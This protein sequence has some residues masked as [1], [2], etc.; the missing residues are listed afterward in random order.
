LSV[1]VIGPR[2]KDTTDLRGAIMNWNL[3]TDTQ[4]NGKSLPV[5]G[6]D[7]PEPLVADGKIETKLG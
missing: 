3:R 2:L 7:F 4:A 6:N 5:S 1:R